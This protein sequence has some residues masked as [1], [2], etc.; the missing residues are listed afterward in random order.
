[1]GKITR[2]TLSTVIA[3]CTALGLLTVSP[4]AS[5]S[6]CGFVGKA[7]GSPIAGKG[8]DGKYE[9][10]VYTNCKNHPVKIKVKYFYA[11]EDRC[12]GPGETRLTVNPNLGAL[13]GADEIGSC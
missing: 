6:V 7:T 10:A 5:A 13:V 3:G 9:E 1:M 11:S 2:K 8:D 4:I 12:V